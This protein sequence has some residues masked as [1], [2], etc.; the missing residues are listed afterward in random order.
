MRFALLLTAA[1]PVAAAAAPINIGA[2]GAVSGKVTAKPTG[3]AASHALAS[4][5]E[6]FH[7]DA[8][9]TGPKSRLQVL[10]KDQTV[11]TMGPDS[12]IILDEFIYDPFTDAGKV[13]A[14]V[15]KG[16]FR[17]VTGKVAGKRPE[18]M[19]I[20]L[21]S[22]T[23]GIRGTFGAGSVDENGNALVALLGPGPD[24]N[25]NERPGG[26]DITTENG[27]QS[28]DEPGTGVTVNSDGSISA[29][30]QLTPEQTAAL[31]A[32]G[33]N[34]GSGGQDSGTGG[35]ESASEESGQETA[36][37]GAGAGQT[38]DIADT[39]Q[40]SDEA[41]IQGI[42]TA[43]GIRDGVAK[44]DDVRT[45]PSGQAH[46]YVSGASWDLSTCANSSCANNSA[47]SM[48]FQMNI[49]FGLA[50]VGGGG[51]YISV[52]D[53]D[54]VGS[55]SV[56]QSITIPTTSWGADGTLARI[57]I[58]ETPTAG[59]TNSTVID[60]LNVDGKVAH[61]AKASFTY[62]NTS[63]GTSGSGSTTAPRFEGSIP[64]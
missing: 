16:V 21:P 13:T 42:Q 19:T 63:T 33:G 61:Q 26:L 9:T 46:Y 24:N 39:S 64:Q 12:R 5:A 58:T 27:S 31:N 18:G 4:G 38:E 1:L 54:S 14:Q 36:M 29:P 55:T 30:F 6:I 2:V 35:S 49:D 52:S 48:S 3:A 60:L 37:G 28:L 47:G 15:T 57:A 22:G 62:Q 20:K 43:G 17:F 51:S 23:I 53:S 34:G 50:T 45:L 8:V 10:L 59:V 41:A 7:K 44:W 25:G 32:G 56:S 40:E 11:F